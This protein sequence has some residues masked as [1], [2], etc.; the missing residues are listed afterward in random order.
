MRGADPKVFTSV[1]VP[2][3][4]YAT[5]SFNSILLNSVA[6]GN[7]IFKIGFVSLITVTT[8]KKKS[9]IKII[10]GNDAVEIAGVSFFPESL[11]NLDISITS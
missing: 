2:I 10:S 1:G 6:C 3:S 4:M 7:L 11:L 8:M 9:S 5:D